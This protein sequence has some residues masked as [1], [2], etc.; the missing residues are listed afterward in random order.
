M[1]APPYID[2][3]VFDEA[4]AWHRTLEGT[5]A[6]WDAYT[7]WL[8]ADL[9]HRLAFDQVELAHRVVD[10]RLGNLSDSAFAAPSL[11][12][13]SYSSRRGW[14]LGALAT[15]LT[16][17]VGI[18]LFWPSPADTV[19]A[20]GSGET[21]RV[22]VGAGVN[23][24]LAPS[25]RLLAHR[26]DAT[27][28]ELVQG[29]AIFTVSHNPRHQLSI[30]AGPYSVTDIGTTFGVNLSVNAVKVGVA[31]G[32]L[33]VVDGDGTSTIVSAGEQLIALRRQGTVRLG[34][35][36]RQDVG[37]WRQGR[38]VYVDTP[39]SVVAADISRFSGKTVIVDPTIGDQS[40]SGVLA[41]GDGSKLLA[42]LGDILGLSYEQ[43]GDSARLKPGPRH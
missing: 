22:S 10:D 30:K 36:N 19:F 21:R 5:E 23:V 27:D 8:E 25:T 12:A 4:E 13:V 26:R 20:T 9:S 37:S 11:A 38:L 42:N 28:L 15:A 41:I 24:D 17:A 35:Y 1:T 39:L 14:M 18:P 2:E 34:V 6:D 7:I 3:R 29:D 43:T 31:E 33:T 16:L 40:F 32:R